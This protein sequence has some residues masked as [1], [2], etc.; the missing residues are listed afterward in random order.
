MG[1]QACL[2]ALVADTLTSFEDDGVTKVGNYGLS[3]H[4]ALTNVKLP[5]CRSVDSSG[6]ADCENLE[7]VDILGTGN[8]MGDAFRHDIK[9]KHLV[10]RGSTKTTMAGTAVFYETPIQFNEGAIYVDE[11]LLS[12]YMSDANWNSY[13]IT[14]LDKYP[15]ST[16]DTITDSWSTIVS[17]C[18][19]GDYATD[20]SIGDTKAIVIGGETYYMQLVAK[21]ADVLASDGTTT[22]PTTWIMYKKY[23][24]GHAM[25]DTLSTAGGWA[26]SSMRSWLGNTVLPLLPAEVQA[27]IKE[28]RKYSG[29]YENGAVVKDGSVTA[30]KLWIPST[31]ELNMFTRFETQG[32]TYSTDIYPS[33]AGAATYPYRIKYSSQ[34]IAGY[35]WMRSVYSATQFVASSNK[36]EYGIGEVNVTYGVVLGFC[37]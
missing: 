37:I 34:G 11:N 35:W 4:L 28:V 20:Y 5:Q 33:G 13:F 16:F 36:G 30:D 14:S 24:T 1:E 15:L 3:H 27:G 17:K 25:N 29:T 22:V 31:H 10:M 7:S 32:A 21:D 9:L 12:T 2:D 18:A 19:N 26:S 6:F 23:Y 8:L